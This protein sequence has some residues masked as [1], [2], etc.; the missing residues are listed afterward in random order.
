MREINIDEVEYVNGGVTNF[1]TVG[2]SSVAGTSLG[3]LVGYGMS[4]GNLI[5]ASL[6]GIAGCITGAS[7][8]LFIV[9]SAAA[10]RFASADTTI[11]NT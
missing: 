2:Y 9:F 5:A 7:F 3:A 11:A 1:G 10:I 6:G 4:N 8:G